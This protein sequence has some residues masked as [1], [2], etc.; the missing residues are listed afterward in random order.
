MPTFVENLASFLPIRVL[1]CFAADPTALASPASGS[2][3]AAVLF[4]DIS[5]FT[6]LTERLAQKGSIGVEELTTHLNAYF[7]QLIELIIA[8]KGDVVKFAGDAM[9]AIWPAE[10]LSLDL[11]TYCAAQCALAILNDLGEYQAA[12]AQ[13]RLHIGIGAGELKEFYIGGTNARWEYLVAGEPIAQ[14]ALAEMAAGIGEACL[15]L[16]AWELIKDLFV[17]QL[18]ASNMVRLEGFNLLKSVADRRFINLVESAPIAIS[19]RMQERIEKYVSLG[20][21]QRLK[22]GQTDW[23]GDLRRVSVMF[24]NLPGI[25]YDAEG[26]L[27]FISTTL[28]AIQNILQVYEGTLNKFLVDDKGST[29]VIGLGL[30]PF[31]HED[32]SVRCVMAGMALLENLRSLGLQPKI[33]IATGTCYSGVIGSEQRREYTIIGAVV[34]LA[35]RL[36]QAAKDGILCDRRTFEFAKERIEFE[37]LTPIKVKGIEEV[38]QVFFPLGEV[39]KDLPW[40]MTGKTQKSIVGREK[41]RLLLGNKLKKLKAGISAVVMICGDAGIGKSCLIENLLL[42]AQ[43]LGVGSLVGTGDAIARSKPYHAWNGVFSHLWDLS[44]LPDLEA[45]KRQILD[46]LEDERQW[47]EKAALLNGV[48]GLDLPDTEV[49]AGLVGQPRAEATRD[50]LVQLLQDSVNRS[51]KLLVFEDAHWLDSSSWALILEVAQKVKRLLLVIGSR[52]IG[53]PMPEEY[54]RLLTIE[55]VEQLHLE[56]MPATDTRLF[57]SQRL[58]VKSLPDRLV[59]LIEK[60][61]EGNPFFSEELAYGLREAGVIEI[62][63]GECRIAAGVGNLNELN[64]PATVQGVI[65]SRIDR[66]SPSEQLTLKVAS[67]IGRSFGFRLLRDIHPIEDDKPELPN[68]LMKL[69]RFDLTPME[70]PEPDLGYMFKHIITQEVAYG[71][72]LYSQ[73]RQVHEFLALWYE[74]SY[75]ELSGFYAI[76]AHHWSKALVAEKAIFYLEKAGD[77]AVRAHALR[78]ALGLFTEALEWLETLPDTVERKEQELRLH[79]ALGAPLTAIKGYGSPE[80]INTFTRARELAQELGETANF[81]PMLWGLFAAHIGQGDTKTAGELA[82]Q[83]LCLANNSE[84]SAMLVTAHHSMGANLLYMGDF[85]QAQFHLERSLFYYDD[86]KHSSLAFIYGQDSGVANFALLSICLWLRGYCRQALE[87]KEQSLSLARKIGHPFSLALAYCYETQIYHYLQNL[88]S[89]KK[90][91]ERTINFCMNNE[92]PFWGTLTSIIVG[93]ANQQSGE[94]ELGLT[95]MQQNLT[96]YLSLGTRLGQ[97]YYMKLTAIGYLNAGLVE[98]CVSLIDKGLELADPTGAY[99]KAEL[100]RIKGEALIMQSKDAEAEICFHKALEVARSQGAVSLERRAIISLSEFLHRCGETE[101]AQ[102]CMT[103]LDLNA[104]EFDPVDREKG[105]TLLT[106]IGYC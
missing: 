106:A 44:F 62:H 53:E 67:V 9:L 89:T 7:G 102:K 8:H 69:Q 65:A 14:V 28:N 18:L 23:L 103:Q 50:L 97:I 71:L 24:L 47:L 46:L 45:K 56:A 25:D 60:K 38:V 2:F 68:Y 48:L 55:G 15:S 104:E 52:P 33:G 11:A 82:Q 96:A 29:L 22:V 49:S 81:F 66:L 72:M 21:L 75:E 54:D 20:V 30:P 41:E 93:W 5:G 86:Q 39:R 12:N 63:D 16:T 100:Y 31:S 83:L 105:V 57:L 74:R 64:F 87:K 79:I 13:L 10:S 59:E 98:E 84:D 40:W 27:D 19:Y 94:I 3:E 34:N 4:V 90:Y 91:G 99:W 6:A 92:F 43:E 70:T 73:R 17:G 1:N 76:M 95:Q 51:P 58:G 35:A 32:D 26:A 77:Q 42:Q 61:T 88:P 78:E 80:L 37:S 101:A 85:I 36:M